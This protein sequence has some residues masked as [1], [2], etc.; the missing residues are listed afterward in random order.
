MASE[1]A[2]PADE[3]LVQQ[4]TLGP[5]NHNE[6][7]YATWLARFFLSLP[8]HLQRDLLALVRPCIRALVHFMCADLSG[9]NIRRRHFRHGLHE[10]GFIVIYQI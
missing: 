5:F 1:W 9:G 10:L 6:A 2:W 4:V 3:R 7:M 8:T